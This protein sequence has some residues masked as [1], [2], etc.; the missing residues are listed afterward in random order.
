MSAIE[1]ALIGFSLIFFAKTFGRSLS[2]C[3]L[4]LLDELPLA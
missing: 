3:E 2:L 4:P 1:T